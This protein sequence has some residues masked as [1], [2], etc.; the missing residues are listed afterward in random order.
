MMFGPIR[1]D[2]ETLNQDA[3]K[4][5]LTPFLTVTMLISG[6][7]VRFSVR[8]VNHELLGSESLNLPPL[9]YHIFCHLRSNHDLH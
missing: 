2:S 3:H 6:K 4:H 9:Y 7:A 5:G 1:L 8:T